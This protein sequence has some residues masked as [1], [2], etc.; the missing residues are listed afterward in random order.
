MVFG[1]KHYFC[2]IL[3]NYNNFTYFVEQMVK[4]ICAFYNF[5]NFE[6]NTTIKVILNVIEHLLTFVDY[7]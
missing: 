7:I 6:M 1:F 4:E 3:K 5:V 2:I